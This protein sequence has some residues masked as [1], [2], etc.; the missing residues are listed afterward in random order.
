[1]DKF[2]TKLIDFLTENDVDAK[3]LRFEESC[4]SAKE[5]AEAAETN[6][7][8]IIKSICMVDGEDNLIVGIVNGTERVSIEKVKDK[9]G[10][11]ELRTAN[12]DEI[13]ERTGYPCG[14]VPAIGY[15]AQFVI[16]SSVMDKEVIYSG[17]GSE[18][19]LL[20]ISPTELKKINDG[21][22]A[23]ISK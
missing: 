3:Q 6:S 17:G 13:L 4:H 10:L 16:D 5:A 12:L 22:I 19:S 2:E 15:Q 8:N 1:M 11:E 9:L 14:G 21:L 18:K 20:K 7:E 23:E